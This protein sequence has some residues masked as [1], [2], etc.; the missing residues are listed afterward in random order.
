MMR[1]QCKLEPKTFRILKKNKQKNLKLIVYKNCFK[2]MS[3]LYL[4]HSGH[5]SIVPISNGSEA[6]VMV[7]NFHLRNF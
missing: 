3:L 4:K 6:T 5:C 1:K 7:V 2:P